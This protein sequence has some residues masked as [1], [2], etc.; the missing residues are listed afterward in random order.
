ME[1]IKNVAGTLLDDLSR[2]NRL[3]TATE[4][5]VIPIEKDDLDRQQ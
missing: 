5:D 1:E 2:N 4:P 3:F